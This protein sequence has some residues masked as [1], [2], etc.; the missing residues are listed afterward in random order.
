VST[1]DDVAREAG[2]SGSTVSHVLNGTRNVSVAT[3]LKVEQAVEALG[4]RQNMAARA[5][6]AGKTLTVGLAVSATA[7]PYLGALVHSIETRLR[8][9]G[10]MLIVGDSRDDGTTERHI[11]DSL[12]SRRVDGIIMTPV[13]GSEISTIPQIVQ[14]GTPFV[15]IDRNADVESDQVT[16]ENTGS[17]FLITNHLI[18]LGHRRLAVLCGLVGVGSS[19]ERLLGYRS[20]LAAHGISYDETLVLYGA[21]NREAAARE[22]TALFSRTGHPTAL[23][24]LNNSMALG[25]LEAIRE[26]GLR[27]PTDVAFVTYDH[28][29]WS[30]LI[31][32]R[33]TSIAQDVEQMGETAVELLLGRINGNE[34]PFQRIQ[35]A[36]TFQH[37]NSCG[38]STP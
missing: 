29:D 36:T 32:P 28:F 33:L 14:A 4:Y 8:S 24:A 20:A 37:R 22:V 10:Y 34:T 9:S 15:L 25:S 35:I 17:A 23:I 21:S 7:N 3:K 27:I 19:T 13:V 5:L 38:C 2:V 26:L 12:L 16:P 11:I 18:E 1:M 31:E 30:D 6:A